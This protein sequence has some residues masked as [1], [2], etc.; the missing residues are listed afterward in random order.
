MEQKG[1]LEISTRKQRQE[2]ER[3]VCK[4]RERRAC[5]NSEGQAGAAESR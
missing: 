2:I 5:S 3:E 4:S 1:I